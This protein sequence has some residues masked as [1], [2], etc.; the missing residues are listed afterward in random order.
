MVMAALDQK[1]TLCRVLLEENDL[2]LAVLIGSRTTGKAL[3]DSDW[4]IAVRWHRGLSS[5]AMLSA[6]EKL[7]S[8]IARALDVSE[9]KIDLIDMT[10]AR[11]AMRALIAEEG[12]PLKGGDSIVWNRYLNRTWRELEEYYWESVYAA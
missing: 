6:M 11:L 1:D 8:R 7:R 5:L 10:V 2:E 3:S 9:D 4:D 12:I